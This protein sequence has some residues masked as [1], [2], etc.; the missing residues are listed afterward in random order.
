ME[1]SPLILVADDEPVQRMLTV[2]ALAA[3]G[4]RCI[5]AEDGEAA[6]ALFLSA[7]PSLIILD[8][9]MPGLNGFE[10]C[11]RVRRHPD[12]NAAATPV[13]MATGLE[14]EES[15][16][17]AFEVGATSFVQKPI[18][19]SLLG[20]Q[21]RYLLRTAGIEVELRAAKSEVEQ[22][23]LTK[24][25][26]FATL[27]HELRT[28]LNGV[29]GFADAIR[30]EMLGPIGQHG[31]LDFAR[32]IRQSGDVLLDQI[33]RML[34]LSRLEAGLRPL[35]FS[36]APLEP[37]LEEA[38]K[39]YRG[40]GEANAAAPNVRPLAE[41]LRIQ[42]DTEIMRAALAALVENA[43]KYSPF[44]GVVELSAEPDD[45]AVVISVSDQ[46]PGAPPEELPRLKE[47]FR[48]A[49]SG[50]DR[51]HG[52][53]GLGLPIAQLAATRHGG[54]LDL[55][56]LDG[57]GFVASLRLPLRGEGAGGRPA[58]PPGRSLTSALP[59]ARARPILPR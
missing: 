18:Q 21:V 42:M 12:V 37:M 30:N 25:R 56:N 17:T 6:A 8:V 2:E 29:I 26:M 13:L 51:S 44:G 46:G 19:W 7:R 50:L 38:A 55:A 41:P 34:L 9:M 1:Q 43:V 3:E 36:S 31:Y 40:Q 39:R 33:N 45:S 23:S 4:Y 22:H 59:R 11:A 20:H 32:D 14:D 52:G 27:C 10:V 15:I 24:S 47:P 54:A 28:P 48:Q 35:K 53:L 57:G 58:R 5:E 49:E 16:Q